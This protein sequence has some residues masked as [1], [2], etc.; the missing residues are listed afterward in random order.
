MI[1]YDHLSEIAYLLE[2]E[3]KFLRQHPYANPEFGYAD[4]LRSIFDEIRGMSRANHSLLDYLKTDQKLEKFCAY[5]FTSENF[6]EGQDDTKFVKAT[7]EIT[8][9]KEEIQE[10]LIQNIGHFK[11]RLQ[12]LKCRVSLVCESFLVRSLFS[13]AS[14]LLQSKY[15][16]TIYWKIVKFSEGKKHHG[17]LFPL[18]HLLVSDAYE[19]PKK[20]KKLIHKCKLAYVPTMQALDQKAFQRKVNKRKSIYID[21]QQNP[22]IKKIRRENEMLRTGLTALRD[23][24]E[25]A[26]GKEFLKFPTQELTTARFFKSINPP[27]HMKSLD[28]LKV[29]VE[30]EAKVGLIQSSEFNPVKLLPSKFLSTEE[31]KLIT[32][33]ALQTGNLNEIESAQTTYLKI[34][35]KEKQEVKQIVLDRSRK[36]Q[37]IVEK[38][39]PAF[40][41][42]D[43]CNLV[44]KTLVDDLSQGGF[45]VVQKTASF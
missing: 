23:Y 14:R 36:I 43:I 20:I 2:A 38:H 13:Q 29:A 37:K 40:F 28:K 41:A 16:T 27:R 39:S 24:E 10:H 19:L 32:Y 42:L 31:V 11:G 25:H 35:K 45:T 6:I 15:R 9:V 18:G 5:V 8:K 12:L 22:E 7:E 21:K 30:W 44:G 17:Y 4:Y 3:I 1:H 34:T 33:E 26:E